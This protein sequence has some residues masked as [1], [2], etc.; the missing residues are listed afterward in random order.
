M[1]K[2]EQEFIPA[3]EYF[4]TAKEQ[5]K[6]VVQNFRNTIWLEKKTS[7]LWKFME[8]YQIN[9]LHG[10][11]QIL[12]MDLTSPDIPW[13]K[14]R[15]LNKKRPKKFVPVDDFIQMVKNKEMERLV[16]EEK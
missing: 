15:Y 3:W 7:I 9:G 13:Y 11:Y 5:I 2:F 4:N 8:V 1:N 10:E 16:R 6:F 12:L 14:R